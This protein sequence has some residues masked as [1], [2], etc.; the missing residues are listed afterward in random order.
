MTLETAELFANQ[1]VADGI[2]N[3]AIRNLP[4]PLKLWLLAKLNEVWE[5]A[6]ITDIWKTA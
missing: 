1:F 6:T 3:Q 4:E 2:T 5:I